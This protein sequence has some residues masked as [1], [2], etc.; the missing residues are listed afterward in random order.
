VFQG[1]FS[2]F[3]E[4]R[5]KSLIDDRAIAA[6]GFDDFPRRIRAGLPGMN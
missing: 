6:K 4:L 1:T 5:R 3:E 2:S